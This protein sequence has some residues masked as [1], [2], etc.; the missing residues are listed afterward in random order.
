MKQVPL[1]WSRIQ[2]ISKIVDRSN[3]NIITALGDD[4]FVYRN[5]PGQSVWCQDL[6]IED[7]HF[8]R[9]YTS[10]ADLGYKSLAVNISD[11]VAM[12][13]TPHF[14]QVS[15]ALP[16][17]ISDDWI[18]EFYKSMAE[19]ADHCQ[20][21]IVGGDLTTSPG[22]IFVDVSL[23]GSAERPLSRKGAQPGDLLICS[24]PLGVS[25]AG[26]IALTN[27]WAD[28]DFVKNQHRRPRPRWDLL[29]NIQEQ[30]RFIRALMDC[31]DGLVVDAYKLI[32]FQGGL[33]IFYENLPLH[34]EAQK[35][36]DKIGLA[37]EEMA[38]WGGEDYQLLAAVSPDEY[39]HFNDWHLVGQ[40]TDSPGVCLE[41]EKETLPIEELKGF[42][43]F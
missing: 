18:E 15:L 21:Q 37:A 24:G 26:L 19:L 23:M 25:A 28:F 11:I 17:E 3:S 9:E 34:P 10:A 6:Q 4:C 5:F 30:A 14:A 13:A 36:A 33:K 27:A 42:K 2:K 16:K 43:H 1:E 31:S 40:F 41:K 20:C 8:K 35:V 22:P 12:G 7:V 29:P 38:L 39:Q 32:P